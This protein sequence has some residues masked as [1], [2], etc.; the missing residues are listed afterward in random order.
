M[1][2]DGGDAGLGLFYLRFHAAVLSAGITQTRGV[3]L[4]VWCRWCGRLLGSW[5][6]A[7]GGSGVGVLLGR[8]SPPLD[9]AA[10]IK[11]NRS[12]LTRSSS[13]RSWVIRTRRQEAFQVGFDNFKDGDIEIV[14]GFI[15]QQ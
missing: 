9:T 12:V 7:R 14:G 1:R 13:R 11:A 6:R 4:G 10:T 2:I 8:N 5:R 15:K 3:T